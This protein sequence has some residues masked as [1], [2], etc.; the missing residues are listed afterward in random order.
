MGIKSIDWKEERQ[1]ASLMSSLPRRG[2]QA[3]GSRTWGKNVVAGHDP[4]SPS[5]EWS[6]YDR[7]RIGSRHVQTRLVTYAQSRRDEEQLQAALLI[8]RA[9][10]A[11]MSA[12]MEQVRALSAQCLMPSPSFLDTW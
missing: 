11:R 1:P 12:W 10:R 5:K 3:S 7:W 4:Y 9:A 6:A 2:R 8:E